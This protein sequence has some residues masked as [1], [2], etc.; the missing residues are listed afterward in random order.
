MS[1]TSEAR[2]EMAGGATGGVTTPGSTS[3][4]SST[5]SDRASGSK[6]DHDSEVIVRSQTSRSSQNAEQKDPQGQATGGAQEHP[7][8]NTPGGAQGPAGNANP[9][10]SQAPSGTNNPQGAESP[11][12]G[13]PAGDQPKASEGGR[14]VRV[15]RLRR[16]IVPL[17]RIV[18][19]VPLNQTS[20]EK[21]TSLT[22]SIVSCWVTG[23][24]V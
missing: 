23:M 7:G 17:Q 24:C 16:R 11:K 12:D 6:G 20:R 19:P 4:A 18:L 14:R 8:N 2:E 13:K 1:T 21:E 5:H 3:R 22:S 10:G 9:Q 15:K